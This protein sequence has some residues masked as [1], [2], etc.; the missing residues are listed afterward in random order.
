[1]SFI[2]IQRA[3]VV[4]ESTSARFLATELLKV[5][6]VPYV[7]DYAT[8]T[9]ALERFHQ[10][11]FD[12]AILDLRTWRTP[13]ASGNSTLVLA[14]HSMSAARDPDTNVRAIQL[15]AD[16][17]LAKPFTR[18][19]LQGKIE[20]L[21]AM[22]AF[23][24]LRSCRHDVADSTRER[25]QVTNSPKITLAEDG[26]RNIAAGPYTSPN[27]ERLGQG[28]V[29]TREEVQTHWRSP[30]LGPQLLTELTASRCD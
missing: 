8:E 2:K 21:L 7:E 22:Q 6:G 28:A 15:G 1:M 19:L 25:P 30:R 23:T 27:S 10:G 18:S 29:A 5:L 24:R 11:S 13:I 12:L 26:A 4:D 9:L 3:I 17:L 20:L 16:T 14:V